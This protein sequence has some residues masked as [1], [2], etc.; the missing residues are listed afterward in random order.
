MCIRDSLWPELGLLVMKSVS[1]GTHIPHIRIKYK[2]TVTIQHLQ[3]G[4]YLNNDRLETVSDCSS[5]L[6][7]N[8]SLKTG[9]KFFLCTLV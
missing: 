3:A 4:R 9:S 5:Y 1:Y 7:M 6:N 2:N 8:V